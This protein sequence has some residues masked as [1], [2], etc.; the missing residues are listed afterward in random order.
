MEGLSSHAPL[1][2]N[3]KQHERILAT[4]TTYLRE[5]TA[6]RIKEGQ[7]ASERVYYYKKDNKSCIQCVKPSPTH[8][9]GL[10]L[11]GEPVGSISSLLLP[12]NN[13]K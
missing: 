7:E 6:A 1:S 2:K 10:V 8:L 11:K 3:L 4:S 9:R 13:G 5:M 12:I